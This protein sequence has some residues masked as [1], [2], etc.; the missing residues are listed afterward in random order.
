MGSSTIYMSR[1]MF[2]GKTRERARKFGESLKAPFRPKGPSRSPSPTPSTD[3]RITPAKPPDTTVPSNVISGS[4]GETDR[5]LAGPAHATGDQSPYPP[6]PLEIA[7]PLKN[8]AFQKA[9]QEYLD[10]LSDDDKK[11]FRS[12]TDVIEKL[13][14]LQ[15]GKSHISSSHTTRTQ[16]AQ[17]VLRCMKQ[18]LESVA[19]CIQHHP[20]VSSLVVG[21]LNCILTVSFYISQYLL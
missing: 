8:E 14:E 10:N 19:I 5:A 6:Q 16:K 20:E 15:Q 1:R 9:I 11:A 3:G 12:A 13:G 4:S 21:G 2:S 17:K 7:V 18:F